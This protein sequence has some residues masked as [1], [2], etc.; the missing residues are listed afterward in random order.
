MT[1]KTVIWIDDEPNLVS[2]E[3]FDL[4]SRGSRVHGRSC[5]LRLDFIGAPFDV[6][7]IHSFLDQFEELISGHL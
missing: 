5:L 3:V 7:H 1:E 4:Q 2:G 6:Q